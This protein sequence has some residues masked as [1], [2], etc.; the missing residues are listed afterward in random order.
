M[1]SPSRACPTTLG[2]D[3]VSDEGEGVAGCLVPHLREFSRRE[4]PGRRRERASASTSARGWSKRRREIEQRRHFRNRSTFGSASHHPPRPFPPRAN[5]RTS[6]E[7]EALGAKAKL[8]SI[9]FGLLGPG[10]DQGRYLDARADSNEILRDL[11]TLPDRKTPPRSASRSAGHRL[12]RS[13][14]SW[15]NAANLSASALRRGRG[16]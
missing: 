9:R 2:G 16:F 12:R 11:R 4:L 13:S 6:A 3:R 8:H 5:D 14:R 7:I 10:R 1:L 15:R